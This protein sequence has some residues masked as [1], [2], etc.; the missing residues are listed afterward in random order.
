MSTNRYSGLWFPVLLGL[1]LLL[2]VPAAVLL[3]L[4]LLGYEGTVNA[5]LWDN[6]GLK[7][8]TY[9]PIWAAIVLL[10]LPL[11]VLLL[12]FLKM[13]RKP[14]EVPSTFL[15]R[16]SIEDLQVNT[17]FQWLRNN[18]LLLLQLLIILVLIYT[19]LAL[20][21]QAS[22][23]AGKYFILLIDN[24]ASMTTRDVGEGDGRITRLEQAKREALAIIDAHREGDVGMVIEFNSEP[25]P[26]QEYTDDRSLL[27]LAVQRIQPTN[28]ATRIDD[29]LVQA[30]SLANLRTS[31]E[32]LSVAPR[33]VEPGQARQ[34]VVTDGI[35]ADVHLF[36]D[37]GFTDG[38]TFAAGNL[39]LLYHQIGTPGP[40]AVDNVGIVDFNAS[41]DPGSPTLRVF[42]RVRN[43]RKSALTC[44]VE[45]EARA[46]GQG[47]LILR[48]RELNLKG[49]VVVPAD[50]K[51]ATPAEDNPGEAVASFDLDLDPTVPATLHAR[52][53]HGSDTFPTDDEAWLAVNPLRQARVLIVTPG[54]PVLSYFF[55][56]EATR[57]VARVEYLK[58]DDLKTDAYAGP[59][60][61]GAYDLVLFDRCAPADEDRMPLANTFFVGDVPPPWKRADLPE[62]KGVSIRNPTSPHEIMHGLT[63]LDEIPFTGAFRFELDPR[64]NPDVPPRTARLLETDGDTAVLFLLERRA[65]RDLVLAFPI[66]NV[67][68]D[69]SMEWFTLWPIRP[70]FPLF[71]RNVLLQM[72]NVREEP[73]DDLVKPGEVMTLRPDAAV[74]T[75]EVW[76]PGAEVGTP[77]ERSPQGEFSF[78]GTEAQGLYRAEWDG[79][80]RGFAVNLLDEVESNVQPRDA[81]RIGEQELDAESKVGK[82]RELW[83]WAAL[84]ALVLLLVEWAFYHRRILH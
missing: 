54:N 18:V 51:A 46:Q 49:R 17:F 84:A 52:L 28:R 82:P 65:F 43:F 33:D 62:L 7:Y 39:S 25:R 72:G 21:S 48:A 47:E 3:L 69:G 59:A 61:N 68:P 27:R 36:T 29:A 81:V 63:E 30:E 70:K 35:K 50:A 38:G 9:L 20:Q 45:V 11:I 75:V 34:Y 26:R 74:E 1:L 80:G 13:R 83:K 71:L 6:L 73:A 8:Q 2:V 78:K 60:R 57:K 23:T 64:K 40:D 67:K 15:W 24:S 10:L 42:L 22:V 41:R 19:A 79:G 16:K 58:P 31:T 77:I 53:R 66:V 55:D 56:N 44:K 12:Y 76:R 32:N 4:A 5:W 14:L 37:G